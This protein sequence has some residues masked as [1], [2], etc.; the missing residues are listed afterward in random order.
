[1]FSDVIGHFL[2]NLESWMLASP[3]VRVSAAEEMDSMACLCGSVL[4]SI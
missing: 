1:M 2:T 4:Y 3:P